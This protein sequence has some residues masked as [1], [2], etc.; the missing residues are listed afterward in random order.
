MRRGEARLAEFSAPRLHWLQA[1]PSRQALPETVMQVQECQVCSL[2]A[3]A[4]AGSS[5]ADF[6]S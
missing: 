6:L 3:P 4:L 5:L 1:L 2:R